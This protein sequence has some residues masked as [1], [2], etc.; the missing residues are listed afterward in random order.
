MAKDEKKK[1]KGKAKSKGK[2]K[3]QGEKRP[4]TPWFPPRSRRRSRSRPSPPRRSPTCR[5]I[6][7]VRFAAGEAGVRYKNR[8]DVM[9]AEDRG[10]RDPRRGLHALGHALRRRCWTARRN[11]RPCPM[12][13]QNGF[14]IVVNSGNA[15]TFTGARG[16]S[17]VAQIA[18]AAAAALKIPAAHVFTSSTGVIGE[19]L[20]RKRSPRSCGAGRRAGRGQGR[21]RRPRHH[22]DRHLSKGRHGR[23]RDRRRCSEDRRFRK[24]RA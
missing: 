12:R 9:L 21:R 13:P 22:D 19:P 16:A 14:A 2:T 8:T 4:R 20:R 3:G 15:N 1:A 17:D 6:D 10:G 7:G 23:G 5:V 24:V 11:W 18:A